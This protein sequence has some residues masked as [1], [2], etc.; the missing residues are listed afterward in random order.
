M[1]KNGRPRKTQRW[2]VDPETGCWIWLLTAHPRSGHGIETR[3][4]KTGYAHRWAYEDAKGK[5]SP[6]CA[7]LQTCGNRLCGNPDHLVAEQEAIS[8]HTR[9]TAAAMKKSDAKVAEA[10]RLWQMGKTLTE[11]GVVV[12]VSRTTVRRWL[13]T[14]AANTERGW[15]L[16]AVLDLGRRGRQRNSSPAEF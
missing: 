3:N 14:V 11:I 13:S 1:N 8:L 12:G 16:T 2:R 15:I 9:G 6:G 7:V 10:L 4:G 5:I